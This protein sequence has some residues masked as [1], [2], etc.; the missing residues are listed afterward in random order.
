VS[1]RR[2]AAPAGHSVDRTRPLAFLFDGETYEGLAGDTIASAL[3]ANGVDVVARSPLR[4]RPR[5]VFSAGVEEPN[6]FVEI[7]APVRRPIEPAT[8]IPL[9]DGLVA[10]SRAGVGRLSTDDG[11]AP[12]AR[13]HHLHVETLVVGGGIAGLRAA[14]E[15][16]EAGDRVLLVDERSWLGGTATTGDV[17]DGE[18]ALPWIATTGGALASASEVTVLTAST[19]LGVYDDGY[20]VVYERSTPTE[21]LHHVR[22]KRVVLATGAHERPIAFARNDLPGVM[23]AS[24]ALLYADRFGAM[25][26]ER[27]IVFSTN[28]A[29]HEAA[30]ALSRAG[31]DVSAIVDPGEGGRASEAAREEGIEVRTG[32][33]VLAGEGDGRIRSVRLGGP[34][35]EVDQLEVDLVLVSGG[36]NPASQLW[37]AIGGGLRWDDERTCFVPDGEGP[38]WLSIVGAAA[39]EVPASVPYWYSPADDLSE[40]FVELQRDS[41]VADV[42]D[43]VGHELRSTE[44]VKRA[45]YIGTAIDQGRTSGA[46]TAAIV[47]EAWGAGPGAQG[48]TNS[49]PPYT[50]VPYSVLAGPDRGPVLLDPVRTTPIHERHVERGAVFENVGQW[51]RPWY[52][53]LP[54][55]SMH[56][57]VERESL[58]VRRAAGVM[59]ASTLGKIELRGPDAATFLDRLYTNR[60]STLAVGSIR[61]GLMLGLDGMVWD[62]GVAM[63]L[64]EDRFLITTTTGGAA[65]VMDHVEEWLQT[66]WP[67]LRVY[68]TS[69]TE[70]WATI[71]VNG[72]LARDVLD[73]AS[74]D[75]DL[76]ARAFPFMTWRDG[77]IAG[78]PARVA[79]VSFSGELA[80]EIN[81]A[82]YLGLAMWDAVLAAGA[83]FG[84]TPYG[85]EAMHVLRAEKG[86]VI[87]GQDTDGTVTLHDLGMSWIVRKDDSDFIGKRSLRRRDTMRP[88]RKH[89]VGLLPVDPTVWLPEG[90]QLVSP[91]HATTPPPV[92]MLG[93]VTSSYRSPV[94]DRTFALAMVRGGRERI[95]GR[96]V[97]PTPRGPVECDVV[98]PS[99]YDPEG[100]RRDG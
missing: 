53:P 30:V 50:P 87:V 10:T 36:W 92:P 85:T 66:E 69:V 42:L 90:A 5:G 4:G 23:L 63:R 14:L 80:Y 97:S 39:G 16:A 8:A 93:H 58:A 28:H 43:A 94:L 88:D 95:G 55:E 31:L 49:R 76:D 38:P 32:W 19:A 51:K 79:R 84:L 73:A 47:N 68:A 91:E 13:H 20:V 48:P 99:F 37:R 18:P 9:V 81:M 35:G 34:D 77:E 100:E 71:A 11:G 72:P 70:Q 86:F 2:L 3:I 98:A 29:G 27:A 22:A 75:I 67:D 12:A 21:R 1:G 17:V 40:H 74:T 52:F 78:M 65:R 46:L 24:S 54:G 89:L 26:G 25:P 6:A 44:H 45:T 33:H 96:V 7:S 82:G 64:A 59:D 60:M 57:A 41:T 56:K 15:A 61:Y 62:D 83:P